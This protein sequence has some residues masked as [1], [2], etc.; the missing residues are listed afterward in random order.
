FVGYDDTPR[1]G[2]F[3]G[4]IVKGGTPEKFQTYFTKL[5]TLCQRQRKDFVFLSA[6]NEWGEG[7][8][9]EPDTIN[10]YAFLEVIKHVITSL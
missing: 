1:R 8:M 7:M 5:L 9:L 3:R 10:K 6:W 4:S 2:V